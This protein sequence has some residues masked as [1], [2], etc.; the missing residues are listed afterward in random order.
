MCMKLRRSPQTSQVL[1]ELLDSSQEWRHGYDLSRRTG[2]KSGTLYPIL[3]RLAEQQVLETRW[4]E[5]AEMGKP[6]RHLYRLTQHGVQ[7]ARD[8][9]SAVQPFSVKEPAFGI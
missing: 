7:I 8:F 1:K 3:L 4:E 2:L 6:P 9:V 5:N